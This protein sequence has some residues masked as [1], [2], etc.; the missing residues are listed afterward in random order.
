MSSPLTHLGD[1]SVQDFLRDYWQK[2]PL[3]VR[4]AFADFVSPLDGDELAGLALEEEAE[5]RLVFEHGKNPWELWRGAFTEE[6]FAELPPSHWTLLVQAVDQWVPEVR[7]LLQRFRFLPDWRLDDVMVS[8][9]PDQGSVGPHFD[10][11][12]VF[13]LQG[14]GKRR[15]RIGQRCDDSTPCRDDTPL[16]I[17]TNFETEQEWLLEPGDLLYIPPGVAHWGI[18]EGECLTYSIGFRAPSHGEILSEVGAEIADTLSDALRYGDG[19]L[20][21]HANPGYIDPNAITQLQKILQRHLTPENLLRWFGGYM[22][23][24]KYPELEYQPDYVYSPEDW[25]NDEAVLERH[26]AARF[27]YSPQD[28]EQSLLFVDGLAY[29]CPL[30]LAQHLC[31]HWEF[32]GAVLK[33]LQAQSDPDD[34]VTQLINQGALVLLGD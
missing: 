4:G 31:A 16:K 24:P 26:P 30:P 32:E 33:A 6:Q 23:E 3:L 8:Y 25:H 15:W 34:L 17:L 22:T 14:P 20:T 9:A 28:D 27:A 7:D 11:Y 10:Y 5:S 21:L 2:K 12:D 13:L 29:P 1:L 18:A 19:D